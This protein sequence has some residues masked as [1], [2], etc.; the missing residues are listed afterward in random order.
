MQHAVFGGLEVVGET[1]NGLR[2]VEDAPFLERSRGFDVHHSIS[3]FCDPAAGISAGNVNPVLPLN[4]AG[5]R[6]TRTS[7]LAVLELATSILGDTNAVLVSEV[8]EGV[9]NFVVHE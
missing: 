4:G 2:N 3:V 1:A 8:A 5:R 9:T 7:R 6:T